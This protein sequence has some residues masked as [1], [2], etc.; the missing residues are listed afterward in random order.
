LGCAGGGG[1]R[2]LSDA[3]YRLPSPS[4]TNDLDDELDLGVVI[5]KEGRNMR[6]AE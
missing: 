1:T 2:Q 5:S 4:A 6:E 3:W